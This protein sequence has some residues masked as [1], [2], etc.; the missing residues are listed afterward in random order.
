V[1]RRTVHRWLAADANFA[2]AYNAWQRETID[3]GRARVLA[4]TD[5]ALDTVQTA[6]QQGNARVAV[7]VA[8]ATGA[9]DAQRPRSSDPDLIRR[10]SK[11]REGRRELKLAAEEREHRKVA[12]P[13]P[14]LR[15]DD[16]VWLE[17]F[18]DDLMILRHTALTKE[19]PEVRAARLAQKPDPDLHC[20][21]GT[22]VL[23]RLADEQRNPPLRLPHQALPAPPISPATAV[24]PAEPAVLGGA[25]GGAPVMTKALATRVPGSGQVQSMHKPYDP[26]AVDPLDDAHWV[27]L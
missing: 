2:A 18:I 7:Q 23:L 9:L 4:M 20:Y 8:K 10:R 13:P 22:A 17:K 3:S 11:L 24:P 5:L 14:E 15:Y 26:D 25:S 6:I 27:N 19:T 16:V 12:G 1:H 21:P